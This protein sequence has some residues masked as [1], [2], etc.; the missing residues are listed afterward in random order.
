MV[1]DHSQRTFGRTSGTAQTTCELH[2]SKSSMVVLDDW[3]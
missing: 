1:D 3:G 2:E